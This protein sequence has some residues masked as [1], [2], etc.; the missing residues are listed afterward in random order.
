M[1]KTP[2]AN[3]TSPANEPATKP[4]LLDQVAFEAFAKPAKL[5]VA[6]EF[7]RRALMALTPPSKAKH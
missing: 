2:T 6:E 5:A 7:A 4:P 1:S 3:G